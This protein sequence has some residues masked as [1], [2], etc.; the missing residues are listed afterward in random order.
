MAEQASAEGT[1]ACGEDPRWS[2]RKKLLQ[3]DC[4]PLMPL[5]TVLLLTRGGR[6]VGG[7]KC[8]AETEERGAHEGSVLF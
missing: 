6:G 8:E 7:S 4:K 1:A 3:T 5:C 2:D